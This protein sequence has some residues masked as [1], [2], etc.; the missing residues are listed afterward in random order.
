MG[1][2]RGEAVVLVEAGEGAGGE[3]EG[4]VE[5]PGELGGDHGGLL[6]GGDVGGARAEEDAAVLDEVGDVLPGEFEVGLLVVVAALRRGVD[7]EEVVSQGGSLLRRGRGPGQLEGVEKVLAVAGVVAGHAQAEQRRLQPGEAAAQVLGPGEGETQDEVRVVVLA[8]LVL[9]HGGAARVLRE[10]Q[11]FLQDGAHM[12]GGL[13]G[14][15]V[16]E[17]AGLELGEDLEAVDGPFLEGLEGDV[18]DGW[19][20]VEVEAGGVVLVG[21]EGG[22]ELLLLGVDGLAAFGIDARG[23][24]GVLLHCDGGVEE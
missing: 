19:G 6:A 11:V 14:G 4:R 13:V 12:G 21:V 15:P 16:A 22:R 17:G 18:G 24:G 9:Q 5:A 20:G 7:G 3:L 23:V 10:G 8:A 1:E 2:D